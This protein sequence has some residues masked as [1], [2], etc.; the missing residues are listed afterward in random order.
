MKS[1]FPNNT[2]EAPSPLISFL[3]RKTVRVDCDSRT[4]RTH[5]LCKTVYGITGG[6]HS[7]H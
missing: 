2:E 3:F 4:K 1:Q 6:M 7:Y 5:T